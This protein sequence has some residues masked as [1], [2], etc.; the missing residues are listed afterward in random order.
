MNL[1][2][3][4]YKTEQ[5]LNSINKN[6]DD[7]GPATQRFCDEIRRLMSQIGRVQRDKDLV[8]DTIQDLENRSC[9]GKDEVLQARKHVEE[10]TEKIQVLQGQI[11]CDKKTLAQLA[12]SSK[13]LE[14]Q[15]RCT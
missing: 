13:D 6:G 14:I 10:S 1:N 9:R 11:D 5:C 2:E 7:G 3:L 8:D 4:K 15:V 12:D